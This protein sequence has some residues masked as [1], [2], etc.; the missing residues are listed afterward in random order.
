[1]LQVFY[2]YFKWKLKFF[3]LLPI[4]HT[5]VFVW[6]FFFTYHI[7][8]YLT[9]SSN[10][11][12]H[13]DNDILFFGCNRHY[14]FLE[15]CMSQV[16]MKIVVDFMFNRIANEAIVDDGIGFVCFFV[17][18]FVTRFITCTTTNLG[19]NSIHYYLLFVF[20]FVV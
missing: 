6:L 7:L 15:H 9:T 5:F 20:K 14:L 3:L 10:Y 4:C 19:W 1:M 2:G 8:W 17:T 12:D 16:L 18:S 11:Q 13:V